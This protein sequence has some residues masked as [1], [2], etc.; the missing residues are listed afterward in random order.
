V[1]ALKGVELPEGL[2][3]VVICELVVLDVE[4]VEDLLVE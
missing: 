3:Q 2:M 4:P 1:F